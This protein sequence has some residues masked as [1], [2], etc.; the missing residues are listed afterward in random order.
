MIVAGFIVFG[1]FACALHLSLSRLC[2]P[3]VILWLTLQAGAS[4][5]ASVRRRAP[6]SK[7]IR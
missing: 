3:R 4:Y 5:N 1:R 6:G 7:A 2:C